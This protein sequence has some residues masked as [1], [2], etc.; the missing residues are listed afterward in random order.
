MAES[1]DLKSLQCGF[2]S[3]RSYFAQGTSACAIFFAIRRNKQWITPDSA[4]N[5]ELIGTTAISSKSLKSC[6]RVAIATGPVKRM[7]RL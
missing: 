5:A 4:Q 3:H 1:K 7:M 2:E 6:G